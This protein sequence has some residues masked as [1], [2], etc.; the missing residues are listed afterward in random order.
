MPQ[1]DDFISVAGA[2]RLA[3]RKPGTI[4]RWLADPKIKITK[5]TDGSGRVWIDR[6]QIIA[7]TTPQPQIP[8]QRCGA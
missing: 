6:N 1:D 3:G 2:A 5:Y 7:H 4:R 8:H